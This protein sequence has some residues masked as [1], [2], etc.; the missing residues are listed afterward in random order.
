MK[1]RVILDTDTAGDDT[2]AIL[3]AIHYFHVEGITIV[4]GNIDFN[5]QVENALYTVELADPEYYIPV[6]KGHQ[7]PIMTLGGEKHITEERIFATDGMGNSHF[8]SAKQR[9]ETKHAVDFMIETIKQNPGEIEVIAIGPQTNIAMAIKRD[10]SIVND[11]KHLWIMGGVNHAPGNIQAVAEFNFFT[12]PEAA[13][14]V[15][16]SGID[17]TMIT[18]D[19]SLRDGVMYEKDL[20]EIAALKTKGTDFFFDVNLHVKAFEAEK[21]NTDGITSPDSL[22][23]AIAAHENLLLKANTYYVDIELTSPL[24]RGYNIVDVEGDLQRLPN[25]RVCEEA[26]SVGFKEVLID[27]LSS[28][29]EQ[30]GEK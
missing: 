22:T 13:K 14:I 10:P 7:E 16:H 21:R 5:Q 29:N 23:V 24:T 30:K 25:I 3:T 4:S 8:P 1:R 20:Q 18:W 15:L 12:D 28:V 17:M 26:D 9:P 2:T 11:I 6:Y 27:V 19:L